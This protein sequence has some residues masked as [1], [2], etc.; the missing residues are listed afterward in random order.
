MTSRLRRW[1]RSSG[2]AWSRSG[3]VRA[4][5]DGWMSWMVPPVCALCIP[6]T[7]GWQWRP[8]CVSQRF[9]GDTYLR[10]R[11]EELCLATHYASDDPLCPCC[12]AAIET[13]L[14]FIFHCPVH[15]HVLLWHATVLP[16]LGLMC[17]SP[18]N[19]RLASLLRSSQEHPSAEDIA[20]TAQELVL[21][22]LR[23][24]VMSGCQRKNG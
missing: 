21:F 22:S 7:H 2:R 20:A 12:R 10:A 9:V 11:L 24:V 4:Q 17:A 1:A 6:L 14:H 16:E 23:N 15:A 3:R 19:V 5:S 13:I 18:D 8:T